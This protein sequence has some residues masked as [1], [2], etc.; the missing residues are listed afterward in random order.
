MR[1]PNVFASP[2]AA[3]ICA[4]LSVWPPP[5]RMLFEAKI[6]M[7]SAPSATDLRTNCRTSSGVSLVSVSWWTEVRSRGPAICPRAMASRSGTSI[8]WPMLCTVVKPAISIA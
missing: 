8:G 6:L 3:V 1:F 2:Q 5:S 4:S 7:T